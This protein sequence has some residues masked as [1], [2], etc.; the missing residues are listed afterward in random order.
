MRRGIGAI[1]PR[2]F[3]E[4]ATAPPVIWML[5]KFSKI[6]YAMPVYAI[7]PPT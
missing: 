7:P 2:G 3:R 1:A 6:L 4:L 5:D